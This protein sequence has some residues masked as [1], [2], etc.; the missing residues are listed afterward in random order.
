MTYYFVE[1]QDGSRNCGHNHRKQA[2]AQRCLEKLMQP[3]A[4]MRK[5]GQW[6]ASWHNAKIIVADESGKRPLKDEEFIF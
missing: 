4:R 5:A 3:T 6:S 2:C 1:T